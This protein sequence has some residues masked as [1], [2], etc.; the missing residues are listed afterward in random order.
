MKSTI[1]SRTERF[2]DHD[3]NVCPLCREPHAAAVAT[4]AACEQEGL[5][6]CTREIIKVLYPEWLAEYGACGSCWGYYSNLIRLLNVSGSFDPRFQIERRKDNLNG[7]L[8]AA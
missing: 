8:K 2:F 7:A 4:H 6:E 1:A 5:G 3:K